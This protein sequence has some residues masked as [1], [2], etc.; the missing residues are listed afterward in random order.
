M[1]KQIPS[2]YAASLRSFI[3]DKDVGMENAYIYICVC[4]CIPKL[5]NIKFMGVFNKNYLEMKS[6]GEADKK[7]TGRSL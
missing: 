3:L 2:N 7:K 6:R 1:I 5:K 4:I